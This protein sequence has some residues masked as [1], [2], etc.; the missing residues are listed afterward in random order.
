MHKTTL[1]LIVLGAVLP[2]AGWLVFQWWK[3]LHSEA[4]ERYLKWRMQGPFVPLSKDDIAEDEAR[5]HR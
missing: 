1:T 5:K 3:L 2:V 4:G